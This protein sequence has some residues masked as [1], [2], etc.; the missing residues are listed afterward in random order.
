M[1]SE[2]KCK[3]SSQRQNPRQKGQR[4][5]GSWQ[6][7][8][9][10]LGGILLIFLFQGASISRDVCWV[11]HLMFIGVNRSCWCSSIFPRFEMLFGHGQSCVPP[12][13]KGR[14]WSWWRLAAFFPRHLMLLRKFSGAR[15]VASGKAGPRKECS[16]QHV[17]IQWRFPSIGDTLIAEN[18]WMVYN[19]QSNEDWWFRGETLS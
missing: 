3:P 10:G 4:R 13:R 5:R 2:W 9:R 12:R 19:A 17:G 7:W 1:T 14:R 11:V 16:G 18:G 8:Q 6:R 15:E